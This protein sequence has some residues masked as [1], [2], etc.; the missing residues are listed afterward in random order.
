MGSVMTSVLWGGGWGGV[1]EEPFPGDGSSSAF[2]STL[3]W[4]LSSPLNPARPAND[5]PLYDRSPYDRSPFTLVDSQLQEEPQARPLQALPW[6][7]G[8]AEG[9]S[10]SSWAQQ[11]DPEGWGAHR[12]GQ[13]GEGFREHLL[14]CDRHRI[15]SRLQ[16]TST[17]CVAGVAVGN[18]CL[19][20]WSALGVQARRASR[21]R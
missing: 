14:T 21:R 10:S 19:E 8:Q 6:A 7:A 2:A 4:T 5:R 12:E 13:T 20:A 15:P 3:F 11:R 1:R 16:Q 17:L 9:T 18:G